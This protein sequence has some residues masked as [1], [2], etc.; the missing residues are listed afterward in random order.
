MVRTSVR[1]S[2]VLLPFCFLTVIAPASPQVRTRPAIPMDGWLDLQKPSPASRLVALSTNGTDLLVAFD[3]GGPGTEVRILRADF[4]VRAKWRLPR[5]PAFIAL[6]EDAV[7]ATRI[8]SA[9]P[10][11]TACRHSI[12]DG[13]ELACITGQ[14]IP[15]STLA[16]KRRAFLVIREHLF[17]WQW[18]A[19]RIAM[20]AP[21]ELR[22]IGPLLAASGGANLVR[23]DSVSLNAWVFNAE[24][25][26]RQS[27]KFQS[28]ALNAHDAAKGP[29]EMLVS[30]VLAKTNGEIW[31]LNAR[32]NIYTGIPI[33]MFDRT[34]TLQGTALFAV[35]Q[36]ED[37]RRFATG[38]PGMGNPTGHMVHS[39]VV[40][41]GDR[42][43]IAD[44]T[45]GRCV[46]YSV[47]K[48]EASR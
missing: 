22:M 20:A 2:R 16:A 29:N 32:G 17:E 10:A 33:T 44:A 7:I 43:V 18:E 42:L 12:L 31:L 25:G 36:F 28:P 34:G 8:A 41:F 30:H 13:G 1:R 6:S 9:D 48:L 21:D 19:G 27:L 14:G 24:S 39:Y 37:L 46:W 47:R 23:L 26:A 38:T 4:S 45:A 40:I 11:F 3:V 35:P 5:A 15:L